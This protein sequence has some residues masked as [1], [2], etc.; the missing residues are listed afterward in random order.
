M[1]WVVGHGYIEL[2]LLSAVNGGL[3]YAMISDLETIHER[4]SPCTM[5]AL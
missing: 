5:S 1:H 3:K 2:T 4:T